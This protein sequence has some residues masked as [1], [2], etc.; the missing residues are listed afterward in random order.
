VGYGQGLTINSAVDSV[1]KTATV[2]GTRNQ[3]LDS[4]RDSNIKTASV[5]EL[6]R[7]DL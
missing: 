7:Q 1:I 5:N 2:E 3:E 6:G 4:Q